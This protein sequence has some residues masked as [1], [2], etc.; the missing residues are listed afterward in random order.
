MSDQLAGSHICFC[1]VLRIDGQRDAED[2]AS[3]RGLD[4]IDP[5]ET[6][7][8]KEFDRDVFVMHTTETL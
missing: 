6:A 5:V 2:I 8:G 7:V 4:R 3:G 1:L